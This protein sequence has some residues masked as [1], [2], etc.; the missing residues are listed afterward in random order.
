MK[1]WQE[2]FLQEFGAEA[3]EAEVFEKA[4]TV[5]AALGFNYCAYGMR[6]FLPLTRPKIV[7]LNNYPKEWQCRYQEMNYLSVDP[8]V[9]HGRRSRDTVVWT[10]RLFSDAQQLWSEARSF[11]LGTG[12]AQSTVGDNSVGLL[13]FARGEG[14][15]T[16]SEL[17]FLEPRMRWLV[18]VTHMAMSRAIKAKC[19]MERRGPLTERE[20]EV[21]KWTADGKT[22]S[23]ISEILHISDNTVN[24]HIK[25]A[26]TKLG[27]ANKTAAVVVAAMSGMLFTES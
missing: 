10:N 4:R 26:I 7:L 14:Q 3:N 15:L 2:E 23:E 20:V 16:E 9:I 25:N 19:G 5:A 13:T 24:F 17:R 12:L 21:L 6:T 11:G 1:S 27:V 22:S 18:Q 8:T